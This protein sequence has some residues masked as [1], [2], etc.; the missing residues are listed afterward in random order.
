MTK[1]YDMRR[2]ERHMTKPYDMRTEERHMTIPYNM[3][4]EEQPVTKSYEIKEEQHISKPYH[5]N[6]NKTS[7]IGENKKKTFCSV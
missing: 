1:L 6:Y 5:K 7:E 3:K 4:R 2:E